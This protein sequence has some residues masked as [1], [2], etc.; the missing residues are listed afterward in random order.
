MSALIDLTGRR[1]DRLEVLA[2][3]GSEGREGHTNAS[4][5]CRCKCGAEVV[6]LGLNLLH[7]NT[8]SC[9]CLRSEASSQRIKAVNEKRWGKNDHD[10]AAGPPA[11]ADGEEDR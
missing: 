11:G 4:W 3:A 10:T 1:F 9:G 6:I 7:H 5:L 2:R 8:R